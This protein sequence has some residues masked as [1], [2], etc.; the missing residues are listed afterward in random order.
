MK[1]E[2]RD[3]FLYLSVVADTTNSFYLSLHVVSWEA[4]ESHWTVLSGTICNLFQHN[5]ITSVFKYCVEGMQ[6]YIAS[7][8]ASIKQGFFKVALKPIFFNFHPYSTFRCLDPNV[9]II[10]YNRVCMPNLSLFY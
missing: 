2:N 6:D 1:Q 7:N 10:S 8:T 3:L 4:K 5:N 9:C